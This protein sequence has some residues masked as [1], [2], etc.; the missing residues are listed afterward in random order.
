M[1]KNLSPFAL[2]LSDQSFARRLA[3][4]HELLTAEPQIFGNGRIF[5]RQVIPDPDLSESN[6]EADR[7]PI[8]F[9]LISEEDYDRAAHIMDDWERKAVS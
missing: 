3:Q 2:H 7:R 5:Q 6:F 1:Q 4:V 9:V 8:S